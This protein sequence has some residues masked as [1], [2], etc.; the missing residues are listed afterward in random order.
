MFTPDLHHH[1]SPAPARRSAVSARTGRKAFPAGQRD[2]VA[3]S[4]LARADKT[5]DSPG[6]PLAWSRP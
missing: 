1:E 5:L 3:A 4:L 2:L 6:R